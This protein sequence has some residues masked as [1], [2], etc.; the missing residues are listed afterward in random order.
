VATLDYA[1]VIR[2]WDACTDCQNPT[3]L[4]A[5]AQTRVTRQLTPA[6]RRTFLS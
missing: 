2:V 4:L 5:L 6:E 1:G 3:A